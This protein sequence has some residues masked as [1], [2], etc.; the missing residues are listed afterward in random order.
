[1]SNSSNP[2]PGRW[3]SRLLHA[4]LIVCLLAV[5]GIRVYTYFATSEAE[6][7]SLEGALA[8]TDVEDWFTVANRAFV[9]EEW[10]TSA[11]V[12]GR[13][14]Q[15]EPDN[16][17]AWVRLGY[18]QHMLKRYDEALAT[19][20]HVSQFDG[21]PRQWAYYNIAA[22]YALKDEKQMALDYL[23]DAVECG[24]RQRDQETPVIDDPDFKSLA[25]DPEFR[26]LAE[27]TKPVSKRGAYRQ[28][29]FL[30]GHW[31][32]TSETNSRVGS[33]SLAEKSEGYAIVGDC[34]D[35]TQRVS[36]T[37]LFF[38]DPVLMKWHFTWLN[39]QGSVTQMTGSSTENNVFLFEGEQITA[40]G[41]HF[42][43]RC[44]LEEVDNGAFVLLLEI[45][46][47]GRTNWTVAFRANFVRRTVT[48]S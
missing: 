2:T 29:D 37:M 8:S 44:T 15:R 40:D 20:L 18:S 41:R 10:E 9:A 22:V 27:L 7:N 11:E 26:R 48:E 36:S 32:L 30:I 47:D 46:A 13:I 4:A 24:Y 19:Y 34:V 33:A 28:L 16:V 12:F 23:Q 38:Y 5:V 42:G 17:S 45:S 43:A 25:D 31:T 35:D 14:I 39:D 6:Q 1:M 3:T 21:R